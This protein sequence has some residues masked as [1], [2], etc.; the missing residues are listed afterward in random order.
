MRYKLYILFFAFA[1]ISCKQQSQE[2]QEKTQTKHP[3]Q[4]ATSQNSLD[5]GGTYH[6]ELP[7]A[8]CTFILT[9]ISINYDESYVLKTKYV[10][11][12]DEKEFVQRGKFEWIDG[13]YIELQGIN[14]KEQ[15]TLYKVEENRLR[16]LDL[17]GNP[18][19]GKLADKYLLF[20]E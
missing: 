16:Q 2:N 9:S 5:W 17:E 10:G 15:P 20:K 14:Q 13:M 19:E 6:G 7:C 8:D 3:D 1:L 11:S 12:E 18:I 4:S